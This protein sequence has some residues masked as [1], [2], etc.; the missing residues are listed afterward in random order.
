MA[1][2][3]CMG[4]SYQ[5]KGMIPNLA[6]IRKSRREP[7]GK[8]LGIKS[9]AKVQFLEETPKKIQQSP[10]AALDRRIV[11]PPPHVRAG[12]RKARRSEPK[13]PRAGGRRTQDS[14]RRSTPTSP[15]KI[16]ANKNPRN[17]RTSRA[18]DPDPNQVLSAPPEDDRLGDIR[19]MR[20]THPPPGPFTRPGPEK[21]ESASDSTTDKR[22]KKNQARNEEA[23]CP[24][25]AQ[26]SPMSTVRLG[27]SPH[28]RVAPRA[29]T[30][31]EKRNPPPKK[32]AAQAQKDKRAGGCGASTSTTSLPMRRRGRGETV[33][34]LWHL[35]SQNK[36]PCPEIA[37]LPGKGVEAERQRCLQATCPAEAQ[38]L[39]I[40][41]QGSRGN[42]E[43]HTSKT[44]ATPPSLP[45]TLAPTYLIPTPNR[46][47]SAQRRGSRAWGGSPSQPGVFSRE[48]D[49]TRVGRQ[50]RGREETREGECRKVGTAQQNRMDSIPVTSVRAQGIYREKESKK[51]SD[52]SSQV[53][54][55]TSTAIHI[56]VL[57]LLYSGGIVALHWASRAH[58]SRLDSAT[59][60]LLQTCASQA[61]FLLS[62]PS[63]LL[64]IDVS[65]LRSSTR[66]RLDPRFPLYTV[67]CIIPTSYQCS[68]ALPVASSEL[69]AS[70]Q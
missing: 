13:T 44:I 38:S 29:P 43:L 50:V 34:S 18:S 10:G 63:L 55:P 58:P 69:R 11:N 15:K 5:T 48:Q 49:K 42:A 23:P 14:A 24:G 51:T 52:A 37:R 39:P 61:P 32:S 27:E 60:P 22:H 19:D 67:R 68:T 6:V 65:I 30:F 8:A 16:C 3:A 40:A 20:R 62:L 4:H 45:H 12:K 46:T 21:K 28:S 33:G 41:P 54:T 56:T 7:I 64:G 35:P 66:R 70:A 9:S 57:L 36:I 17:K 31:G 2:G 53:Y 1:T 26:P 59:L 47:S 25:A